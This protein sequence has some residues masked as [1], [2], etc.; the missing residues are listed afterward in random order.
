MH[1]ASVP[2]V[3]Q[4][5]SAVAAKRTRI[6]RMTTDKPTKQENA[7]NQQTTIP[8]THNPRSKRNW[9]GGMREIIE[10]AAPRPSWGAV[11]AE[12]AS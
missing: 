12:L 8:Q 11:R 2:G 3:T 5:G 7:T 10:S 4:Q 6:R 9:P 1:G